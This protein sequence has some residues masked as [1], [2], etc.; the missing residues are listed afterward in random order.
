M[1]VLGAK[2][3]AYFSKKTPPQMYCSSFPQTIHFFS[4][5][6]NS[7]SLSK[8]ALKRKGTLIMET[9]YACHIQGNIL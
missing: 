4:S 8:H 9:R 3:E 7:I 1:V 5:K 6:L 2:Q